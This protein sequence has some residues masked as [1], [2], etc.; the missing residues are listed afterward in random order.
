MM[1]VQAGRVQPTPGERGGR[2]GRLPLK[3]CPLQTESRTPIC[4]L[5]V[6]VGR[7]TKA[8]DR[9]TKKPSYNLGEVLALTLQKFRSSNFNFQAGTAKLSIEFAGN[10][11]RKNKLKVSLLLVFNP[12]L[13]VFYF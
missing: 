8:V 1:P 3:R 10:C 6:I 12:L 7:K 11:R 9:R 2:K 13:F 4:Q 5:A